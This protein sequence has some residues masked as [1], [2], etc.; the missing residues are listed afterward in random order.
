MTVLLEGEQIVS[1]AQGLISAKK[2]CGSFSIDLTVR[3]IGLVAGGGALDFGGS[4]YRVASISAV[5]PEKRSQEEPYGW[6]DLSPG[7][8]VMGF[9]ESIAPEGAGLILVFPHSRLLAAGGFH[10]ATTLDVLNQEVWVVLQ[11]G[12]GGLAIKENARVSRA[13]VLAET[14]RTIQ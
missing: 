7:P 9:N 3:R 4:E 14:T 5:I 6:W 13:V 8:Y 2:Q 1:L 12:S 11:V 10:P